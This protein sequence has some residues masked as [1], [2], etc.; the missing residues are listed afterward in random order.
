MCSQNILI[1]KINQALIAPLTITQD[2]IILAPMSIHTLAEGCHSFPHVYIVSTAEFT[3]CAVDNV[4]CLAVPSLCFDRS[5]IVRDHRLATNKLTGLARSTS[6]LFTRLGA[7]IGRTGLRTQSQ[8]LPSEQ[9]VLKVGSPP[10][11][12]LEFRDPLRTFS[13]PCAAV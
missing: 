10:C 13:T 1:I 12:Y 7:R 8:L 2:L 9:G 6:L 5:P 3:C 11:N 4:A